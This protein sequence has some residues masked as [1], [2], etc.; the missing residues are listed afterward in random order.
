MAV[1][2]VRVVFPVCV[3]VYQCVSGVYGFFVQLV[4]WPVACVHVRACEVLAV[5][6]QARQG[7]ATRGLL[8]IVGGAACV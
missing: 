2:S 5:T 7:V 1:L 4:V 8:I 3:C 6:W